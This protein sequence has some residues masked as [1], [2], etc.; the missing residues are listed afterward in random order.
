MTAAKLGSDYFGMIATTKLPLPKGKWQF[1][2]FS[3]DGAAV[4]VDGKNIIDNWTWHVPTRNTGTLD[5]PAD[6]IVE[7]TVEHFEIDGYATLELEIV[8]GE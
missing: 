7:I 6:K 5:L 4:T 8:K 1:K 2:T 3:D